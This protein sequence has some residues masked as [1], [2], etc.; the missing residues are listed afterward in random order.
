MAAPKASDMKLQQKPQPIAVIREMIQRPAVMDQIRMAMPKGTINPVR[1]ARCVITEFQKNDSLWQCD[2]NSIIACTI[3]SAQLGL[4]IGST[5]GQAYMV[6]FK[7]QATFIV[8]YRGLIA[9]AHRSGMV[10]LFAAHVVYEK[11]YFAYE[12][13]SD[14]KIVHRPCITE[15]R[16][17]PTGCYAVLQLNNG[18]HDFEYLSWPEVMQHGARYS[19]TF[20]NQNGPWKTNPTEMAR[21]TLIR[22]LAKR[23]PM[24][25]ELAEAIEV[26]EHSEIVLSKPSV[27]EIKNRL[28]E[29][30]GNGNGIHIPQDDPPVDEPISEGQQRILAG[31]LEGAG[32]DWNLFYDEFH[33]GD[34]AELKQSQF[35]AAVAWVGAKRQR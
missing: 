25:I 29:S 13:G 11:D 26:D 7:G 10:K 20:N 23:C 14:P 21:K 35:D 24:S 5:L 28:A 12:L 8:G 19:K 3:Q 31:S 32:I 30:L 17:H 2:P 6:P 22:R 18:G 4:E 1:M 33:V 9:L 15:E 34:T 16:G 27:D